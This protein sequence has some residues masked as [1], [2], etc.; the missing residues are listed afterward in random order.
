MPSPRAA[1]RAELTRQLVPALQALGFT[2]PKTIAGNGLLHEYRRSGD[3]GAQILT[4]QLEK[5]GRPRFLLTFCVEPAGGFDRLYTS[6]GTVAQGRL[7]PRAGATTRHWFR[8]DPPF[9]RRILRLRR[10]AA[11]EVVASCVA[12]LPEVE[13][14]WQT[15]SPSRHVSVLMHRFPGKQSGSA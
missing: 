13:A 8:V 4:L 9:L 6:G 10:P 1:L 2:G 14:W 7:C 3:V 11:S 12:L 5:H 15:Q